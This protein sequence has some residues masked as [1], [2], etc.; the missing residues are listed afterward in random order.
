[1][2]EREY[3]INESKTY[4]GV[5]LIVYS[6]NNRIMRRYYGNRKQAEIAGEKWLKDKTFPK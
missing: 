2:K 3:K 4:T 1:M 5:N 6:N